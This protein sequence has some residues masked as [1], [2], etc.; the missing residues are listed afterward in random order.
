MVIINVFARV[1]VCDEDEQESMSRKRKFAMSNLDNEDTISI[2]VTEPKL[3]KISS[4]DS[5]SDK[6]IMYRLQ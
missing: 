1:V 6:V 3:V 5:D 4:P 2:Y